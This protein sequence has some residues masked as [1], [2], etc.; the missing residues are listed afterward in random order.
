M[1]LVLLRMRPDVTA[2]V[3]V[4]EEEPPRL[5]DDLFSEA[6]LRL[7]ESAKSLLV[8]AGGLKLKRLV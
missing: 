5:A 3:L 6:R 1:V 2:A 7:L 4:L 8:A